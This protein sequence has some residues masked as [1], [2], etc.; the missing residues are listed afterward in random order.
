[1]IY[2]N[3]S[4]KKE[5]KY[6]KTFC[7][8]NLDY[9]TLRHV[10]Q[11]NN[12][13]MKRFDLK[14][15]RGVRNN[16]PANIRRGSLWYGLSDVQR[17]KEFCQFST[18]AY[19]IR[20]FFALMRTYHYKYDCNTIGQILHRFAPLCE[21]DT[22]AYI[23]FVTKYLNDNQTWLISYIQRIDDTFHLDNSEMKFQET[24]IVNAW[25]N[26]QTPSVVLRA[27]AKAVFMMESNYKV[28]DEQINIAIELL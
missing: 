16:N 14:M 1:M 7:F 18:M 11:I 17:D 27:F 26:K 21:N 15:T 3:K 10:K 25:S 12:L 24:S 22:Y 2:V 13:I 9:I 23:A 4:I 20:A 8:Y 28:S 19:G 6:L 5:K